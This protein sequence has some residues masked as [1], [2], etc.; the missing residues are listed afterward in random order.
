MIAFLVGLAF[1]V[2]KTS[3][4]NGITIPLIILFQLLLNAII[5]LCN[6]DAAKVLSFEL[7][8]QLC[9]LAKQQLAASSTMG[10]ALV[11]CIV[12]IAVST[13]IGYRSFKNNDVK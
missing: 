1:V 12:M 8:A 6:L 9:N 13:L 11:T 10:K 5:G 3:L 4:F 2:K 7:D